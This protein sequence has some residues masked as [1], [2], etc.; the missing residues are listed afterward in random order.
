MFPLLACLLA[1]SV[2]HQAIANTAGQIAAGYIDIGLA[3]GVE[4]MT[5]FDML[6][7]LNPEK[8]SSEVFECP[9]AQDCLLAMGIT[10]EV[11]KEQQASLC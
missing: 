10:S 5:H 4:S 9:K 6:T 8:L 7:A 1:S 11:S 2:N 3:G